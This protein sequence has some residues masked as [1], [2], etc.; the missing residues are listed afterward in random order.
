MHAADALRVLR[1]W[2]GAVEA[3]EPASVHSRRHPEVT[4]QGPQPLVR[5]RLP[6]AQDREMQYPAQAEADHAEQ[7]TPDHVLQGNSTTP[8]SRV[9]TFARLA[10]GAMATGHRFPLGGQEVQDPSGVPECRSA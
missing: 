2:R 6:D 10:A 8:G 9:L 3:E 7:R 5:W 4:P 1:R